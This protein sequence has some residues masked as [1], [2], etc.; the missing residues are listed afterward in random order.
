DAAATQD[1][2]GTGGDVAALGVDDDVDGGVG[3]PFDEVLAAV[4]DDD[5]GAQ[6]FDNVGAIGRRR[7]GD[8]GAQVLGELDHG[9]ADPASPAVH[10]DGLPWLDLTEC[11]E[12]LPCGQGDDGQGGSVDERDARRGECQGGGV[13][14]DDL[15]P[16]AHADDARV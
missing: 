12:R 6:V 5:V 11:D 8:G 9:R 3:E 1:A 7:R 4:V 14:G 2:E 15:G 13:D 16:G 10:E